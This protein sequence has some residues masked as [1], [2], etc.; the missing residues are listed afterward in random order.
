MKSFYTTGNT[1]GLSRGWKL[2]MIPTKGGRGIMGRRDLGLWLTGL[3]KSMSGGGM[4]CLE[5]RKS[6]D[7]SNYLASGY[8]SLGE[9]PSM[10]TSSAI[11]N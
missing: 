5:T 6:K 2:G 9:L 8:S 7:S 11:F 3:G 1:M 10:V 4:R